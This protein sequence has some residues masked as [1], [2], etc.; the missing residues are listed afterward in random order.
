MKKTDIFGKLAALRKVYAENLPMKIS[1]IESFAEK[2]MHQ[3]NRETLV[4]LHRLVHSLHGS[5]GT[6]GYQQLSHQAEELEGLLKNFLESEP[7]AAQRHEIR[8]LAFK[9]KT[10]EEYQ[11]ESVEKQINGEETYSRNNMIFLL[12]KD[13]QL[14]EKTSQQLQTFG[15]EIKV[16]SSIEELSDLAK[17][18]WPMVIIV[19]FNFLTP[20]GIKR[21]NEIKQENKDLRPFA[22]FVVGP[23]GNFSERLLA[24]RASNDAYFT[25]PLPMNELLEK[26]ESIE[27]AGKERYNI[28]IVE[29]ELELAEYYSALIN[30]AGM[31]TYV[32]TQANQIDQALIEFKPDLILMDIYMPDCNGLEL[33]M[34][35]R[36]QKIYESLPIVFLSSENDKNKQLQALSLGGDDFILKTTEAEHLILAIKNKA[37]R[38]KNLR[39]IITRDGLTGVYNH[40]SIQQILFSEIKRAARIQMPLSVAMV[41]LDLFK[42]INDNYGHLMGDQVLKHFCL[43]LRKRLRDSDFIGRYG[44]EE[45]LIILPNTP[46]KSAKLVLDELRDKFAQTSFSSGDTAFYTTFSAGVASYPEYQTA[47][48]LLKAADNALYKAKQEGSNRVC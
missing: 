1:Q 33:A 47:M 31:D 43:L 27:H 2:L 38:Y 5:A 14:V 45:F 48:D 42:R 4:E 11:S 41:D 7:S 21:L 46:L 15:C 36:Q 19:D 12:L 13:N 30:E 25:L 22:M 35:I 3:W 9:L 16:A 8:D 17:K 23:R 20:G 34:L 28:L 24:L 18:H 40:T 39:S 32:I 29:D 37:R 6:Y 26:I 44:G 10:I